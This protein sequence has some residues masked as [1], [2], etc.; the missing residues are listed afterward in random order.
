[1]S[2]A[3]PAAGRSTGWSTGSTARLT[4]GSAAAPPEEENT[5][6]QAEVLAP[7]P[8]VP[9]TRRLPLLTSSSLKD[10][11][12]CLRL[13]RFK[14]IDAFRPVADDAEALRFG[15]LF[16]LGLEAWWKTASFDE[17]AFE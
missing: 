15:I 16:H 13:Y 12:A 7:A 5:M 4:D 9:E 10:A 1:M 8:A 2:G 11:R 14:H 17:R 3:P 6:Q